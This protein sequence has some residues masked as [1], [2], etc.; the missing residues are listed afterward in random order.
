MKGFFVVLLCFTTWRKDCKKAFPFKAFVFTSYVPRGI[1]WPFS[2]LKGLMVCEIQSTIPHSPL[3]ALFVQF[4]QG[5]HFLHI[6]KGSNGSC[7]Q[8]RGYTNQTGFLIQNE[9]FDGKFDFE[10]QNSCALIQYFLN[11]FVFLLV[12]GL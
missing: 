6:S 5:R 12:D 7:G 10:E 9:E 4:R 8:G 2:V 11:L 3:V 1:L